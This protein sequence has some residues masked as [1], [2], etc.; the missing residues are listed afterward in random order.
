VNEAMA[1]GSIPIV[2]SQVGCGPDLVPPGSGR[3]FP[4]GDSD[5]LASALDGLLGNTETLAMARK[6][7]AQLIESHSIAQTSVGYER[8]VLAACAAKAS[9]A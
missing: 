2:S 8:A 6:L 4:V 5:A 1:A 7:S 9:L 3:V